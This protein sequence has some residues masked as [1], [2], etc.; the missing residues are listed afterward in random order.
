[1]K[2]AWPSDKRQQEGRLLELAREREVIDIAEWF[3]YEQISIEGDHDTILHLR[4]AMKFKA[5]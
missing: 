5:P 3:N 1:M 2:L 4:R